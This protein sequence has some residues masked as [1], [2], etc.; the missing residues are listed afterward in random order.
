MRLSMALDTRAT[1]DQVVAAFT[2]FTDRRLEIWTD[3][4][5]NKYEV[6]ELGERWAVVKE[7]SARPSVWAVERYD[8]SQ[9][10]T[11]QWTAE[12]SNFCQPGDGVELTITRN[13]NGGAHVE[14]EWHR[15][16]KGIKGTII[17]AMARMVLP[18]AT[19]KAWTEVLDRYAEAEANSE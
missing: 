11:V 3:L 2:D 13:A 5:P 16:G 4:D 1:P 6:R 10:G 18:R 19:P 8:W 12:E 9:P 17:V 15:T 14:G 7:G